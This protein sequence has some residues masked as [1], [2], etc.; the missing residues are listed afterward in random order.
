MNT[1]IPLLSALLLSAS[2]FAEGPLARRFP[3]GIAVD[4]DLSEWKGAP[5]VEF[6]VPQ[7]EDLRVENAFFGWNETSL[8]LGARVLDRTLV[9][10][11]PVEKLANGDCLELRLG[12][13]PSAGGRFH[14]VLVAP[15]CAE[16]KPALSIVRRQD[17]RTETLVETLDGEPKSGATWAVART[18]KNWTV[19]AQIPWSLLGIEAKEGLELPFIW[20]VW[21]RDRA[22][23]DEWSGW[24][25]RAESSNQKKQLAESPKLRLAGETA[26][27]VRNVKAELSLG[28]HRPC[29]IF[30][31]GEDVVFPLSGKG[32]PEGT[33]KIEYSLRDGFGRAAGKAR[34]MDVGVDGEGLH[35]GLLNLERLPRGYYELDVRLEVSGA[36]GVRAT[37]SAKASFGVADRLQ[38]DL[39][40]FR[41]E[42]RRFGLKWWGGVADKAETV[43]MMAYLGLQW[44]RAI[45]G[46]TPPLIEKT[47]MSVVVKVE[48]F[49]KEL[50]DTEKYGPLADWEAKY[51]RGAWTL[52]T[53]PREKEYKEWLAK[54]LAKLPPEQ[55]VFEI[56][57]EPW[58]KMSPEDISTI[59]RWIAEVIRRDRP[60]AVLGPNL[61][62]VM[63]EYG[64][65]AKV[66]AAGGM[67]GMDMVCLH[68]YGSSENRD[69][70][71]RYR[72]WISKKTGRDIAIYITEYGSH[73]CPQGPARRTELEQAAAVA[74]QSL[75]LY[76]EDCKALAPHW[77]GQSERNP[78]YHEDWSGYNRR[79]QEPK[80]VLLALATCARLVDGTKFVGDLWFGPGVEAILFRAKDST[81]LALYTKGDK[82]TVRVPA[83]RVVDLF[84]TPV[85]A[86]AKDGE[87]ELEVGGE[88][89]Y[90][91][92]LPADLHGSMELRDDRWPAP[93]KPPRATRIAH[94][95]A[96]APVFDGDLAEWKDAL[97]LY[98][99]NPKV[100]GDDASGMAYLAWDDANLYVA[101]QMRD[102]ELLNTRPRHKSYQQ[103]S[104]ELFVSA[105]PRDE[106]SG[107]GPADSQF[108]LVPTSA[109]DGKP[110]LVYLE[111]REAG[112]V[113][114][115]ADTAFFAGKSGPGWVYEAAIP[116]KAIPGAKPKEGAKLALEIR[117]NDADTSHER[118]KIDPVDARDGKVLPE[119][120]TSWSILELAK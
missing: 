46:E 22:D 94:R 112:V 31:P 92:G 9:N 45:V 42:D 67:D 116:W 54:E 47:P 66:V 61:A 43:E 11:N 28:R 89:L 100:A 48:R 86:Q 8:F 110:F 120:P 17:G 73:S 36:D 4:G 68:P 1:H 39:A 15:T 69:W 118:W 103:D 35:P 84:G 75:A 70:L 18:E 55:N 96:K 58:D 40:R 24:H 62:G 113:K 93:E 88:P 104:I 2:V 50:F 12:G 21:D 81:T 6:S 82:K 32:L 95:L 34:S 60:G 107:Y 74:R 101:V 51:G 52:K 85:E 13:L 77:V 44:T 20:V 57:N 115:V 72:E 49:P 99:Q 78:T 16:G 98:M 33:G 19:E 10:A 56:W 76:A 119:D 109:P 87:L 53:L 102:N 111:E 117:V 91:T 114:D 63:S 14:C 41:A 30:Q 27:A 71:R 23:A 80:P 79:N 108:F 38:R 106:D 83:G 37:A 25:K 59:S 7:V 90:V 97:S 105:E 64:F 5:Q 29:N 26:R 3:E 65:D